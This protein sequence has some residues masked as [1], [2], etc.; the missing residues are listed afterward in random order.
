MDFVTILLVGVALYL[1][2]R[3]RRLSDRIQAEEQARV[4]VQQELAGVISHLTG[5]RQEAPAA[6]TG[7]GV[8]LPTVPAAPAD[9]LAAAMGSATPASGALWGPGIGAPPP[10][11]DTVGPQHRP[12]PQVARPPQ[13][14][15]P[16]Q[17]PPPAQVA[18]RARA[19]P[20]RPPQPKATERSAQ[21]AFASQPATVVAPSGPSPA[22]RLLE[23]LGLTPADDGSGLSR[24]AIEAWL[25]GRL[26]AV[27][28]GVALTLGAAFFL[29]LAFSRG[30]ITE[31]M[32]VL[33]GLAGGSVAIALG[34]LAFMRVKGILGH[35]LLAVGLSV[36]SLSLFAATRLFGLIP[37]EVGVAG[38]LLAAVVAAAIAIRH[39]SELVAAFGLISVLAAPPLLGA[40]PTSLTVLFLA[41]ALVGTT[42]IALFK[43]WIWLPPLAFLLAAPQVAASTQGASVPIALLTIAGFWL[44]NTISAGGEEI[45]HPT[46]RLQPST[47]T[48]LLASAAFTLWAGTAVLDGSYVQ[49][50]GAFVAAVALAYLAF[51][52]ALLARFGDRHPFGLVVAATGIASITMA[53]PIQFGATW[54][55][56]AWASEAVALTFVATRFRHPYAAGIA[57]LLGAMS[58]GHLLLVEYPIAQIADGFDRTWPFVGPQGLTFLFLVGSAVVA[59]LI[60]RRTWICVWLGVVGLVTTAYV[61]PFEMSDAWLVG[62]WSAMTVAGMAAW[63]FL[64]TPRLSPDFAER[65]FSAFGLPAWSRPIEQVVVALSR[66]SG[67]A[68]VSTVVLLASLS[69]GHL[70]VVEYSPGQLN[71]GFDR[72]WPFVGPQGLALAF[73]IGA[74]LLAGLIVRAN[75]FRALLGAAAIVLTAYALPF[76]LSGTPLVVAWSGL[77]VASMVAWRFAVAGHLPARFV[78]RNFAAV[79]LPA[80]GG[81]ITDLVAETSRIVRPAFASIVVLPIS[82]AIGHLMTFEFPMATLGSQ[83]I[84]GTPYVSVEGLAA[85]A[86]LGG[87]LLTGILA[88]RPYLFGSMGV[89]LMV[90]IYTLPFEVLPPFVMIPWGLA[91]VGSLAIVRRL[92]V[93][94]P[95]LT[96]QL[97]VADLSERAP[98][99]A[100]ALGLLCMYIDALLYARPDEFFGALAGLGS[101][102]ATPFLDE[103]T[104]AL[105]AFAVTV[106]AAGWVWGGVTARVVGVIGAAMTIAWLLPFEVRPAYAVAGWA[107]LAAGGF[108]LVRY[109]PAARVLAGAPAVGLIAFGGVVALVVVAP[110][111]RLVV[112]ATTTV[113]GLPFLTDA[114]VALGSLAVACA[115]GARLH[116]ADPLSRAGAIAAALFALYGLS[117]GLVDVFQRQVGTRPLEDLQREA[118]LGLSLLWS[119]LGGIAFAVGIRTHQAPVRRA[120]LAL[121][122]LATAKVFIVDLAALDVAY[123]VL[124]L[125][126]LGVLLL[127]SALVYARQQPREAPSKTEA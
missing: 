78:E 119:V 82:L 80:A 22:L 33:I 120:G 19:A 38:A 54:V 28:G 108:G 43:T 92:E 63:R 51:G 104:F 6:A 55:P 94:D 114:T 95:R 34:E 75:W 109:V 77:T 42:V 60:V 61:L 98:Y 88:S 57:L 7:P 47:V 111:T 14:A 93:V 40:A 30:W 29:S 113:S 121:L 71:A 127:V 8:V 101:L 10:L 99:V 89:A 44:V 41:A 69:L 90:L 83:V 58:L 1:W 81:S 105:A 73:V 17:V 76:E 84:S 118:Q 107:A 85:A 117:V 5:G 26:L 106:G 11:R 59:G 62:A 96:A 87:L 74:M 25:E 56:I 39:D 23:R 65:Q 102:P 70:L 79:G 12:A 32:R 48:L 46:H 72:T 91:A 49:W 35:V 31:P 116:R 27:V 115:I 112:D 64:I 53:V 97:T 52:L 37:P 123:R 45:R 50:R 126:G 3:V 66:A 86:V 15:K 68:F 122:G 24:A 125:V 9:R 4:R 18:P 124:S 36:V 67:V 2:Y 103:R 13:V 16:V 21:A 100:A 20:A 110:P